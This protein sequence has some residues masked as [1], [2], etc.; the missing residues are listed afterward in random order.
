MQDYLREEWRQTSD[1]KTQK[2]S[3]EDALKKI[4][5]ARFRDTY[6]NGVAPSL[7]AVQRMYN[8]IDGKVTTN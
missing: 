1:A 5:L 7:A 2:L 8:I 4:D 6:G 3:P